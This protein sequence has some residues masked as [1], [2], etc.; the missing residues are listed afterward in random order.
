[1][2]KDKENRTR[3][4]YASSDGCIDEILELVREGYDINAKDNSG[5]TPLHFAAIANS[6]D[7]VEVLIK[8]GAI[9]EIKDS[10]GNTP[11]FRSVFN[12]KGRGDIIKI[13]LANG[14]DPD[15]KNNSGMSPRMLASS[16]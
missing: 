16:I 3:L 1:M 10:Y 4:H 5:M 15:S 12:S 2:K 9:V 13:L 14:A 6:M 7:A 8:L 11:L